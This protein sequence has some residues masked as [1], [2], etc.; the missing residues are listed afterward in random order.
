MIRNFQMPLCGGKYLDY[1][2][3]YFIEQQQPPP[4][5]ASG[6]LILNTNKKLSWCWQTCATRL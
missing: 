2:P 5:S 6:L 4:S 3:M 1:W